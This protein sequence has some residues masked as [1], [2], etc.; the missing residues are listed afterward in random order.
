M[1]VTR[2]SSRQGFTL[3]ELLVVIS[4]IALLIA[5]LLP[6]LSS[7]REAARNVGCLSNQRQIG[8]GTSIY[9]NDND[10]LPYGF[11]RAPSAPGTESTSWARLIRNAFG[12]SGVTIAQTAGLPASEFAMFQ[13]P[14]AANPGGNLHYSANPNVLIDSNG[15]NADP[16]RIDSLKRASSIVMAF[17]AAQRS[18]GG[19]DGIA[20]QMNQRGPNDDPANPNNVFAY[21][22]RG[23]PFW[24]DNLFLRTINEGYNTDENTAGGWPDGGNNGRATFRYRHFSDTSANFLFA[25][26]HAESAQ[27]GVLEVRQFARDSP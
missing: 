5:I 14:T 22:P 19:A 24:D 13:C 21:Y 2:P 1:I 3:I 23:A 12:K 11:Y 6:T 4:I 16:I 20:W 8:L 27:P 25:D 9:S 7:A 18:F 15:N 26:G 17:D 10:A